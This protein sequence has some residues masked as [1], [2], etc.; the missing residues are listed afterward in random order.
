MSNRCISFIY[1][2][3]LVFLQ[4]TAVSARA[5]GVAGTP[6]GESIGPGTTYSFGVVPQFEQR[7]LFR[8]WRPILDEIENRTG[9]TLQLVGTPKIPAFEKQFLRGDFDFAYMNPY[10]VLKAHDSQGY[11]PLVRDGGRQLNGVIVVPKDSAINSPAELAGKE[12][13]LPAPNALGASML[14]RS[15]L[16]NRFNVQTKP[17]Y[18]QTHSSVYLHVAN[19]LVAAGGGVQ[20]TLKSQALPVQN[21]L[22]IIYRTSSIPPHPVT[23]HPR[24]PAAHRES[25]KQAF[26]DLAATPK[27]G[28]MLAQIPIIE[29]VTTSFDDYQIVET[30]GLD[31]FYAAE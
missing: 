15:D 17:R 16:I 28:S 3:L 27:G 19:R 25:V 22:R 1:L 20:S 11:L 24:V 6:P 12:I 14:V 23:A 7:K 29:L 8:I 4:S 21:S 26:L 5:S 31:A 9:L 30:L 2:L 18:V 13:A 10:H